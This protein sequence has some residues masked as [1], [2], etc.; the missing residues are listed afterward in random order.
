METKWECVCPQC[1]S[2]VTPM[3]KHVRTG[4]K[5]CGYCWGGLP[6][7]EKRAVELAIEGGLKP[8][9][10]YVNTKTPWK[11]VCV[12]R[13]CNS[14]IRPQL[15]NLLSG[16]GACKYCASGAGFDLAAPALV[17]L[18]FNAR[19]NA[20]K[21]G[22]C[23]DNERNTRLA[24]HSR[25]GWIKHRTQPF[26]WGR[27][28]FTVEQTVL[29]EWRS[30]GCGSVLDEGKKYVGYKETISLSQAHATLDELWEDVEYLS[31]QLFAS[32]VA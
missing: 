20:A 14:E 3:L 7:T 26:N 32:P 28:A 8:K 31:D 19:L 29:A 6:F 4:H 27:Q 24:Q 30:W 23:G 2:V 17:Y 9:S 1:E 15:Q 25:N 13:E 11:G 10:P 22:I 16:Q 12:N 18:V 5:G 21:I